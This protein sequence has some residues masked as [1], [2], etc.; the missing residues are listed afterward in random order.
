MSAHDILGGGEGHPVG[1][2]GTETLSKE[3][4]AVAKDDATSSWTI[5]TTKSILP[6]WWS[7]TEVSALAA[8]TPREETTKEGVVIR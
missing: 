7:S 8:K 1:G 5:T 3:E 2:E 4:E 6:L